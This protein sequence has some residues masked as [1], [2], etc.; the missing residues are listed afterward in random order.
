M[1]LI[2]NHF[3]TTFGLTCGILKTLKGQAN[4]GSGYQSRAVPGWNGSTLKTEERE[5]C[6]RAQEKSVELT[7]FLGG[8]LP[9][10]ILRIEYCVKS[11]G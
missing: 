2:C 7:V 11:V 6:K 8:S 9:F 4:R 10:W 3:V 1:L 5:T